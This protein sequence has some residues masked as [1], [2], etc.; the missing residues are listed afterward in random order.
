MNSRI[1]CLALGFLVSCATPYQMIGTSVAGGYSSTQLSQDQFEIRFNGNGFTKP[2][3]AYDFA[4][5]RAADLS[6][7]HN[8]SYFILMGHQDKSKTII[9]PGATTSYTTGTVSSSNGYGTYSG[10]TTSYTNDVPIHKPSVSLLIRCLETKEGLDSH[11]G[12]VYSANE[13]RREI[14]QQYG[15]D[16]TKQADPPA[17][18]P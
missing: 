8:Y 13:I 3:Q 10:T 18:V 7:E 15:L 4:L 9:I 2:K 12:K 6:L 14:R 5:L 11:V 16:S 17:R 1:A